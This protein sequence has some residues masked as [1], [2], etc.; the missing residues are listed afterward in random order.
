MPGEFLG[1][2]WSTVFIKFVIVLLFEFFHRIQRSKWKRFLMFRFGLY[3]LRTYKRVCRISILLKMRPPSEKNEDPPFATSP[4]LMRPPFS[5]NAAPGSQ[6]HE[7]TSKIGGGR[8][9]KTYAM[10]A[11]SLIHYSSIF[12]VE[13]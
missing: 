9:K 11:A 4:I 7:K 8:K 5:K 3:R 2:G 12:L 13:T 1:A 10:R 6:N